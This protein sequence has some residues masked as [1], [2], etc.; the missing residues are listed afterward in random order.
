MTQ[1]HS[2]LGANNLEDG[3]GMSVHDLAA[4]LGLS[5]QRTLYHVRR[6]HGAGLVRFERQGVRFLVVPTTAEEREAR[7]RLRDGES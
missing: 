2:G 1:A 3:P 4:L 6:L 5:S 7:A